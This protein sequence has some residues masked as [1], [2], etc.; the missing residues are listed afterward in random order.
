MGRVHSKT[1][2]MDQS[3][4]CGTMN[5][6]QEGF[7]GSHLS[8][9]FDSDPQVKFSAAHTLTDSQGGQFLHMGIPQSLCCQCL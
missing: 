7:V 8:Q 3:R 9:T 6:D 4:L 1:I 2:P 5:M